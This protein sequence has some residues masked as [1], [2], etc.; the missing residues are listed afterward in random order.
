ME[1]HRA[2]HLHHSHLESHQ[3]KEPCAILISEALEIAANFF[4]GYEA[5]IAEAKERMDN[6][7]K[8]VDATERCN[9][10]MGAIRN[11]EAT[12]QLM[13]T[14]KCDGVI[15]GYQEAFGIF[16]KFMNECMVPEFSCTTILS[17]DIVKILRGENN[18]FI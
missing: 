5:M 14:E 13:R 2:M 17:D 10:G 18:E 15:R 6:Y 11:G 1:Y 16:N 3:K 9:F 7:Q 4:D 12:N 8:I